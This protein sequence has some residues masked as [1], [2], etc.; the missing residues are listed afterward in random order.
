MRLNWFVPFPKKRRPSGLRRLLAI[1]G[2]T[3]AS[4]PLRRI[5]QTLCFLAFWWLFLYVCWP[6]TARPARS[7]PSWLPDEVDAEQGNL[8][9]SVEEPLTEPLA[10]GTRWF[11]LDPASGDQGNLGEFAVLACDGR[12]LE[13]EPVRSLTQA[14]TDRLSTS[15]GPWTLSEIEPG[16]WPS[17]YA[18]T[19]LGKERLAAET[20]LVLDPLVSICTALASRAWVWSLTAAGAI[21]L[22]TWLV[23]RGFCGYLCPLGTL[24]DLFDWALAG[25]IRRFR[26][27]RPG[28][29]IGRKDYL[30]AAVRAASLSGVLL[31]GYVAAIPV[32]TRAA[33]FLLTPVQTGFARDWHQIPSWHIGHFISL[34]LFVLVLALG[35]L[36]PRFW[37]KFVCPTGAVFSLNN[38][39]RT[40]ERKVRQTCVACGKCVEVCPFDAITP[41][42]TTR[43]SD[44]TF[45][46]TCGGVCPAQSIQFVGR[47]D[48]REWKSDGDSSTAEPPLPRRRFLA[49]TA[50]V[51]GGVAGGAC[52]A[53]AARLLATDRDP[54]GRGPVVRPPGSVPEPDFLRLCIR[55][56]ECYQACPNNVLQPLGLDR[57]LDN[58]WT[59]HVVADWSGCEP[60]CS[61]CGQVCPTGA[62][63]ALLLDEKRV[64]RLGLAAID[65]QTCLPHAGREAC[66]LCVDECRLAGYDAFE[67]VRVGT[68]LDAFGA[69]VED[70]G[71][72]AP[73]V[74]AERCVGCGL[75]Q[76]RCYRINV[77]SKQLL[78]AS[79]VVVQA[80]AGKEDR[81]RN[82]SYLEQRQAEQREREAAQRE[83]HKERTGHGYLPDFLNETSPKVES[84]PG[85]VP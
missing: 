65:P 29:W 83:L 43:T 37:C 20:F 53:M 6:Y 69:L 85:R 55:C 25:R 7:V 67:F 16:S 68:E 41:D 12:R 32:L 64:A 4:S 57:G 84:V 34:A 30:L 60:S 21:L 54:A 14:Q 35:L 46:Q 2:T 15:F 50:G 73:A 49:T 66:Q 26:V 13:L 63:R 74:R 70:S 82:G 3:W 51:A 47:W 77:K 1:L 11:V 75:C 71:F 56:G 48:R 76:T 19:F 10:A 59:P 9:L 58:L 17:H 24:I 23:P 40:T 18:D 39:L 52:F 45:C 42:F 44:C 79:A 8:A 22:A 33:A 78:T 27:T 72:L 38:L 5:V 81:L 31:A 80:G 36:Q 62:I 28:W 61:N